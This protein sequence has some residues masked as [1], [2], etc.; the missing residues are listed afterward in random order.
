MI[1]FKN[2]M[3]VADLKEWLYECPDTR[4]DGSP[5]EVWIY[6]K[7]GKSSQAFSI[8]RL[9]VD[10]FGDFDILLEPKNTPC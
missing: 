6:T 8:W 3:S 9:N 2:G 1:K 10:D 7:N 4:E 5:C